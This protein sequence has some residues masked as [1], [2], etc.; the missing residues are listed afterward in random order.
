M[1]VFPPVVMQRTKSMCDV[2]IKWQCETVSFTHIPF[3]AGACLVFLTPISIAILAP[4]HKSV[5]AA[6]IVSEVAEKF[7]ATHA[8]H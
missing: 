3:E 1:V 5:L 2:I 6:V 7:A 4:N 8:N